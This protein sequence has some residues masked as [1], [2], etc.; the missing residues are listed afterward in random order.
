MENVKEVA[1]GRGGRTGI[2]EG[3]GG[4]CLRGSRAENVCASAK[5]LLRPSLPALPDLPFAAD[6]AFSASTMAGGAGPVI[7]PRRNA[8][9]ARPERL[10]RR[11]ESPLFRTL[12]RL[13][14][15]E[16]VGVAVA[17]VLTEKRER[18]LSGMLSSESE[19]DGEEKELVKGGKGGA[20][21]VAKVSEGYVGLKGA[22][23]V[24]SPVM[25]LSL[26]SV[27]IRMSPSTEVCGGGNDFDILGGRMM[28]SLCDDTAKFDEPGEEP[29][30]LEEAPGDAPS[31]SSSSSSSS[32]GSSHSEALTTAKNRLRASCR[33][34]ARS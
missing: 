18:S 16:V 1:D 17:I 24:V 12:L 10:A 8:L 28:V 14:I 21:D 9:L 32:M 20:M 29:P 4:C 19:D 13:F 3:V 23:A 30:W 2:G 6:T 25:K 15:G 11:K 27:A 22:S 7:V 26:K 5:K 31:S 34:R 33:W